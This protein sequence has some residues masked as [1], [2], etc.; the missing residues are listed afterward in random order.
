[1]L[2]VVFKFT[3]GT[4]RQLARLFENVYNCF[5]YL[6]GFASVHSQLLNIE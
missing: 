5:V 3:L 6:Q 1:M 4:W 2:I